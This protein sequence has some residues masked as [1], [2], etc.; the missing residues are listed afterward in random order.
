MI[1]TWKTSWM[2]SSG[3]S[4]F[5]ALPII[6]KKT[7][8]WIMFK[9]EVRHDKYMY[10]NIN[11]KKIYFPPKISIFSQI[12][13]IYLHPVGHIILSLRNSSLN[14]TSDF[15]EFMTSQNDVT[16]IIKHLQQTL[17]WQ[18]AKWVLVISTAVIYLAWYFLDKK[19]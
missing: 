13:P 15:N 19:L 4:H 10:K 6:R 8:L 3:I 2:Q 7:Q 12:G 1:T 17:I 5:S 16:L 14:F 11:L 18:Y 9:H